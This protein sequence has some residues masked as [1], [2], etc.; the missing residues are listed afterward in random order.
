MEHGRTLIH[1]GSEVKYAAVYFLLVPQDGNAYKDRL[2][3]IAKRVEEEETPFSQN[4]K[5]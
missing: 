4:F 3:I 2:A 1:A 5:R